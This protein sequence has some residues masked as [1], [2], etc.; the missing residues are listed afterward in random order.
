MQRVRG[1]GLGPATM[2]MLALAGAL[3]AA[4][5]PASWSLWRHHTFESRLITAGLALLTL[6]GQLLVSMVGGPGGSGGRW[7]A[8]SA[9][10]TTIA[11]GVLGFL[12]LD[13]RASQVAAGRSAR[14]HADPPYAL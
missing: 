13:V 14:N 8:T 10:V 12:A 5:I 1:R 11:A 3:L 4:G 9:L 2:T 6:S 7:D